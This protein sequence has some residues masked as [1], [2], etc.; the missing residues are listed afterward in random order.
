MSVLDLGAVG[1]QILLPLSLI[2]WLVMAPVRSGLGFLVQ[3]L[4][5]GVGLL[6]LLLA[7]VWI[8]PPWWTPYAY[9]VLWLA[10]LLLH[11]PQ[12]LRGNDW[13]PKGGRAW[14]LL[15]S[16]AAL[17]AYA[18]VVS[19]AAIEGRSPPP[20]VRVVKLAFPFESGRYLI[21]NGGASE[22]VNAH[23]LTLNPRTDRQRAYRGQSYG[24]DIVQLG[25]LGMRAP[26]WRPEE[27]A[28]YRIFGEPVLAPCAGTVLATLD[29]RRDMPVPETDSSPLE[30]NHVVLRCDDFIVLLAHLQRDGV[31]VEEG[32]RV[33]VGQPLGTVGNSGQS[34]EPH[35]HIHAQSLPQDGPILSGEPYFLTFGDFFPVRNA[36][37]TASQ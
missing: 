12:R 17:A 5:T 21:A 18:G 3:A 30:G 13:L 10:A 19:A 4:A 33:T 26:G 32:T 37:L 8:I 25:A 16:F 15:I 2:G 28:A 6:A 14:G 31:R 36:R 1:V 20:G 27:P 9:L 22:I 34:R 29:G 24:V 23:F 35:L 11:A 7:A